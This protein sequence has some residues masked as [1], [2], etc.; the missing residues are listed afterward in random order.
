MRNMR[1]YIQKNWLWITVGLIAT[2]YAVQAAYM[3][4]GYATFGGEWF[5]L[6]IILIGVELARGINDTI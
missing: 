5:T 4:R 1:R 3:E 6:P 2:R